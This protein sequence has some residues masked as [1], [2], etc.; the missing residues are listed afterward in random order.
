M[1]IF[2]IFY[3]ILCEKNDLPHIINKAEQKKETQMIYNK[4]KK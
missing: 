3:S 4:N 1:Y 2:I